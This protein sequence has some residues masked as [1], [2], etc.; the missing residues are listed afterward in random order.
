MNAAFMAAHRKHTEHDR[1]LD[2]SA[3]AP[4]VNHQ[5][6]QFLESKVLTKSLDHD[7]KIASMRDWWKKTT[8]L[9]TVQSWVR[10]YHQHPA[11]WGALLLI[12]GVPEVTGRLRSK[13]ENF[14]IYSALFLA[15]AITALMAPPDKIVE[16]V[17]GLE[18]EVR[19][20]IFFYCLT[21]GVVSQI[22]CIMLAMS[23]TNVLNEAARDCDVYRMFSPAGNGFKATKK[24]EYSY[25]TGVG[26][27]FIAM[28][29]AAHCYMGWEI[30]ILCMVCVICASKIYSDTAGALFNSA[31]IVNYWKTGQQAGDPYDLDVL[32]RAFDHQAHNAAEMGSWED[33]EMSNEVSDGAWSD[34]PLMPEKRFCS[35]N[36]EDRRGCLG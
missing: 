6:T 31:S 34:T 9:E 12:H 25:F 14:A 3:Y 5:T 33:L 10:N 18:C 32:I 19:K 23:F 30:V 20:R 36:S 28:L 11:G 24:V 1:N 22:L 4:M 7:Q 17:G 2:R 8:G 21:V 29:A 35:P 13:V 27:T 26:V 15:T 16:C